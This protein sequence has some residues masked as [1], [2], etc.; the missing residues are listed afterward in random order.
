MVNKMTF[1]VL[2]Y[3]VFL[4]AMVVH[5]ILWP[6]NVANWPGYVAAVAWIGVTVGMLW[7]LPGV[8]RS[9]VRANAERSGKKSKEKST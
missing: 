1:G 6:E 2:I 9:P 3:T 5:A 4:V 7:M 8:E